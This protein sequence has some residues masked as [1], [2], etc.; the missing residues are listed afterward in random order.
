MCVALAQVLLFSCTS[1]M[2]IEDYQWSLVF[3]L[4]QVMVYLIN[5]EKVNSNTQ[6]YFA[7]YL[8]FIGE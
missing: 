1:G 6:L 2:A 4:L 5:V 3:L 7:R 8:L